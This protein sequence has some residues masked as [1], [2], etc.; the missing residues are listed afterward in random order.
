MDLET[1]KKRIDRYL[2]EDESFQ[3]LIVDVQSHADL[4]A[5]KSTYK[6]GAQELAAAKYCKSDESPRLDAMLAD[7]QSA[8]TPTF[9]FGAD[10]F[11]KTQGE[12]ALRQFLRQVFAMSVSGRVVF[13]TYQC[14]RYMPSAYDPR[15]SRRVLIVDGE[16]QRV[17]KIVLISPTMPTPAKARTIKGFDKFADVSKSKAAEVVYVVTEKKLASFPLSLYAVGEVKNHYDAVVL[18]DPRTRDLPESAGNDEQWK[19]ALSLFDDCASWEEVVGKVFGGRD[20]LRHIV[21][22]YKNYNPKQKWLFYIAIKLF[23]NAGNFFIEQA[24]SIANRFDEFPKMIVRGLSEFEPKDK[25]FW[26][27]YAEWKD[28]RYYVCDNNRGL[29]W[30]YEALAPRKTNAIFYLTDLSEQE[31]E[32][33]FLFL[34][35]HGSSFSRNEL[36]A[37]LERVY[38]ELADYMKPFRYGGKS[39]TLL[40]LYFQDYKCQKV[41]NRLDESFLAKVE[42]Q[43]KKREYNLELAPRSA[44]VE[45]IDRTGAKLY[46]MD[47]MGVEFLSYIV[48]RCAEKNLSVNVEICR[49]EL[50]TITRCNKEFVEFFDQKGVENVKVGDVDATK[51]KGKTDDDNKQT[52]LPIYLI[53]ELAVIRQ[54]LEKID[55]ELTDGAISRAIMIADHGASRLATLYR[56]RAN[57]WTMGKNG[58]HYGRCCLKSEG[59]V[60]PECAVDAGDYWALANYDY[61]SGGGFPLFE[62][63]GGATLEEVCVPIIQITKPAKGIEITLMTVDGKM[64][65]DGSAPT[66]YASFKT[67]AAFLIYS[68]APL[69]SVQVEIKDAKMKLV[70]SYGAVATGND[71]I[72][73]VDAPDLRKA[74]DYF[75]SVYSSGGLVAENLPFT[76]KKEGRSERDLL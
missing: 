53:D 19:Y 51:H 28:A 5:I 44:V 35:V 20:V 59:D 4:T 58:E 61:F 74:G 8:E 14:A 60:P 31:K 32:R 70:A 68:S 41:L 62:V 10:F 27:R 6:G 23:G 54:A 29:K 69:A 25:D 2:T 11:L 52:N 67:K 49:A 24:A 16:P 75:A 36:I 57:K 45:S 34:S 9:F 1:C 76:I 65:V 48:A 63:H 71:N 38:P 43:G 42:D 17:P 37:V 55:E 56:E 40:N 22:N 46:F 64:S 13:V 73:R 26:K 33:I 18:Q 39:E 47:A 50:P 3:P 15:Q 12:E 7:A 66:I 30:Y 21:L 72:Y